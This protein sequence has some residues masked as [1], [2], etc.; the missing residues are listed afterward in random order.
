MNN[1]TGKRKTYTLSFTPDEYE[2]IR[3]KAEKFGLP[4]SRL[5][6]LGA[7]NWDGKLQ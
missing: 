6:V 5:L 7:I 1:K 2:R 3:E 4:L